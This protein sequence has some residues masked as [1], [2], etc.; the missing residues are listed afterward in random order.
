MT[1][2]DNIEASIGHI[3]IEVTS[4]NKSK[5]FY[6]TL[7]EGLGLKLLRDTPEYLGFNNQ[8]FSVWIG[9]LKEPRVNRKAPT[10][11]EEVVFDH[12]AIHVKDKSAVYD[13]EE[14]MKKAGFVALFPGQEQPQFRPGYFAVSFC[15]PDNYVIEICTVPMS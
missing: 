4:L 3:G 13:I 15:D 14:K 10:G 6:K 11:E 5:V 7:L 12:L 1:S 8:N 9:E 2:K